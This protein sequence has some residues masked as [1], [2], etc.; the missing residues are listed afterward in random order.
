VSWLATLSYK[1]APDVLLYGSYS[2]GYKGSGL[3]LN[4]A[5]LAG[6]PL[7]LDPEKVKGWEDGI[8]SQLFEMEPR[9]R[10]RHV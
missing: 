10:L 2:T 8:K 3:K 7:A 1:I 5:V 9:R 4:A 6:A